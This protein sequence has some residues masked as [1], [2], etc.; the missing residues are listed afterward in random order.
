[1]PL[2]KITIRAGKSDEYRKVLLDG[3]HNALVHA[4]KIPEQDRFQVLHELDGDRFEIPRTK[5]DNAAIIEITAF[6]GRTSEAKKA[7]YQRIVENLGASPG[8]KGEDILI[9]IHEPP[10]E[11]WGIRGGRPASEVTM[12]FKIDV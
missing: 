12:G 4:F 6:K 11:N 5:T 9:V 2:A 8:I 1:M 7:L 10:L 3:V